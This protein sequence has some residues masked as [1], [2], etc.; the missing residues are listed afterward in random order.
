ME[1]CSLTGLLM[2][3][4]KAE[5]E[6]LSA[7]RPLNFIARAKRKNETTALI[8]SNSKT[9]P[10]NQQNKTKQNASSLSLCDPLSCNNN[11]DNNENKTTMLETMTLIN[12]RDFTP[13]NATQPRTA[14]E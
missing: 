12:A 5:E 10:T 8:L 13:P 9:Q 4:L 1:N 11:N 6:Q 2:E 7:F 3:S 14:M